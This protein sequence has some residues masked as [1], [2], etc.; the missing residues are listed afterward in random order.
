MAKLQNVWRQENIGT[1]TAEQIQRQPVSNALL[2]LQGQIPGVSVLQTSG[3]PGAP[4]KIQIRGINGLRLSD[5][6]PL[7]VIDGLPLS[8]SI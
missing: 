6:E 2:P 1:A 7:Y 5:S 3:L 4:V 8:T